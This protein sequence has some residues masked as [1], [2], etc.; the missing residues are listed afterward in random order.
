MDY[1]LQGFTI[2][3]LSLDDA[4]QE[5]VITTD[6]LVGIVGADP[7]F[8]TNNS[9]IPFVVKGFKDYAGLNS[10][11]KQAASDWVATNYPSK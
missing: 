4:K 6:I 3:G 7:R 9:S 10:M 2:K 1:E 5:I 8:Q 11:I